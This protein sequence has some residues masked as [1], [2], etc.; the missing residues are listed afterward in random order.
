MNPQ[1]GQQLFLQAFSNA[2]PLALA[3][4]LRLLP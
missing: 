3:L 2:G 4:P 1:A